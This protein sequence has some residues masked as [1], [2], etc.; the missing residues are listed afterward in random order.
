MMRT[1]LIRILTMTLFA[2]FV[3]GDLQAQEDTTI[4]MNPG[5]FTPHQDGYYLLGVDKEEDGVINHYEGCY[6]AYGDS[7]HKES[8]EQNGWEYGNVIIFRN[9]DPEGVD[10]AVKGTPPEGWPEEGNMI[11]LTKHKYAL[12]DSAELG[13]LVSPEFTSIS[14]LEVLVATDLSTHGRT[15]MIMIEASLDGGETWQ[16]ADTEDGTEFIWDEVVDQGGNFL[17]YTAGS[18]E[19]FDAIKAASESG[20]IRL[21]FLTMPAQGVDFSEESGERL[22]IWGITIEAKTVPE[23]SGGT[24][25]AAEPKTEAFTIRDDEFI[26]TKGVHELHVYNLSG[27]LIGSGKRVPACGQGLYLVKTSNGVTKKIYLK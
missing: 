9:C 6:D 1:Q 4:V 14:S 15:I 12:S 13:Y 16:Y 3:L 10:N 25:L 17:T 18:S 5:D 20:P 23:G 26:A 27:V 19:S 22:K 8:G 2:L 24:V 7:D 21:R 11:Q